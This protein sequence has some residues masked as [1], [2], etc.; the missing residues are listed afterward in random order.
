MVTSEGGG[1]REEEEGAEGGGKREEEERAEGGGRRE[2]EGEEAEE[3]GIPPPWTRAWRT[4]E[5]SRLIGVWPSLEERTLIPALIAFIP[6]WIALIAFSSTPGGE[7]ESVGGKAESVGGKV[8]SVGG[9][10]ESVEGT[11]S[12][13]PP[14]V[15]S[16]PFSS[17]LVL[18][19]SSSR[20]ASISLSPPPSTLSSLSRLPR[21]FAREVRGEGAGP[22]RPSTSI[23]SGSES[24]RE[25]IFP[26][27][28]FKGER[29]NG[30][31]RE[32]EG[33]GGGS[34]GKTREDGPVDFKKK[35]SSVRGDFFGDSF[36]MASTRLDT[37]MPRPLFEKL[38]KKK[39]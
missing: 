12:F 35:P 2:E 11:P 37:W 28:V 1:K 15:A 21:T 13:L 24:G 22:A 20:P 34:S 17:S 27:G 31:R 32:E 19:A 5:K 8:E 6:A 23:P 10:V 18:P 36:W 26:F 9:E 16:W 4:E 38:G 7:V 25:K 30:G 29:K 33:E 39:K 3:G 14:E